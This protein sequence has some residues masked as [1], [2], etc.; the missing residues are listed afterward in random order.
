MTVLLRT[1]LSASLLATCCLASVAQ[2]AAP[3]C[4]GLDD[5][6]VKGQQAGNPV[7]ALAFYQQ[8]VGTAP[9]DTPKEQRALATLILAQTALQAYGASRGTE[10]QYL[11][12]AEKNFQAAI[13]LAPDDYSPYAGMGIVAANRGS[14]E[15]ALEWMA[16]GVAAD[17]K[18]PMAYVERGNFLMNTSRFELAVAD[19]SS[20]INLLPARVYDAEKKVYSIRVGV[21]LPP[22][23]Q[24]MLYVRRAQAYHQ[25]G[26]S[27]EYNADLDKACELGEK[28]ACK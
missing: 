1:V 22:R 27:A 7:Q 3:D 19:F 6:M 2:A 25:L 28:R 20:A 4:K 11:D 23:E 17:A 14:Q 26:K 21:N 12:L 8:G 9:A 24:A 5:C 16:K 18:D 13:A 15:K 10:G